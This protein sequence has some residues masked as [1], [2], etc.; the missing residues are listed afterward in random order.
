MKFLP[1][2]HTTGPSPFVLA[3][4]RLTLCLAP[5]RMP[6]VSMILMLS[7]T[8]LG[9]CAHW[10]LKIHSHFFFNNRPWNEK[11]NSKC[12]LTFYFLNLLLLKLQKRKRTTYVVLSGTMQTFPA[13]FHHSRVRWSNAY[14]SLHSSQFGPLCQSGALKAQGLPEGK[15]SVLPES[16]NVAH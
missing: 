5:D 16:N 7:R 11:S 13:A 2:P 14:S 9:S 15:W 4:P 8:W 10:N 3:S 1:F 12:F 6:G